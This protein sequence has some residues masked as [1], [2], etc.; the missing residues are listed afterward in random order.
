MTN[1]PNRSLEYKGCT[2]R[3]SSSRHADS[4]KPLFG[5]EGRFQKPA[6]HRPFLTSVAQAK[7]WIAD[8]AVADE[9]EGTRAP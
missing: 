2:I 3:R 6:A 7:E 4:L 1:H 5:I 8:A 9:I